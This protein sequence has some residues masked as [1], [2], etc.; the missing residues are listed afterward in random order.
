ME[1]TIK[2]DVNV[3]SVVLRH[4]IALETITLLDGRENILYTEKELYTMVS[5]VDNFVEENLIEAVNL[6]KEDFPVIVEK[7]IEPKFE[8]IITMYNVQDVYDEL[9]GYVDEYLTNLEYKENTFFGFFNTII[10]IVGDMN[11]GDLKFFFNKVITDAKDTLVKVDAQ[12][13]KPIKKVTQEEY[14]G[15]SAKMAALIDKFQKE[16]ETIEKERK[17]NNE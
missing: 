3:K 9:V 6:E 7:Y 12:E 10:D 13:D 11:W 15:A 16:K 4:K 17:E 1:L 5:L 2:K 8:E 14:E